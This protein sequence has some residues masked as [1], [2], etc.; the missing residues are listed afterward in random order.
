[1]FTQLHTPHQICAIHCI[2]WIYHFCGKETDS[3]I[4]MHHFLRNTIMVWPL[5]TIPPQKIS[6]VHTDLIVL[7]VVNDSVVS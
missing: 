3:Q 6:Y 7:Q 4:I 2:A 5:P 1:M